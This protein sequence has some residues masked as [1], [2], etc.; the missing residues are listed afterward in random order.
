MGGVGE[1]GEWVS[2][3]QSV[4]RAE[5]EVVG[6]SPRLFK[7]SSGRGARLLAWQIA[8]AWLLFHDRNENHSSIKHRNIPSH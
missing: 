3:G 6:N 4:G 7:V 2:G 8:A 1:K 5:E